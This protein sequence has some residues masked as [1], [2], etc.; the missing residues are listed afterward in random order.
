MDLSRFQA[1]LATVDALARLQ[2]DA[3]RRGSP[4]KLRDPS[5]QLRDL[6]ELCGLAEALGVE[7]RGDPEQLE[8]PLGIEE[9]R[10]LGDGAP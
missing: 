1:D 2:L 5:P 7:P 3:R 6:I 10:H 9:E 8:Q 4:L